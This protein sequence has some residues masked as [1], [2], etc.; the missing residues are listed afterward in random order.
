MNQK[1]NPMV[2][3][4]S[5][6]DVLGIGDLELDLHLNLIK[7][8]YLN[9]DMIPVDPSEPDML[10]GLSQTP[11]IVGGKKCGKFKSMTS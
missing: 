1:R 11:I 7:C 9:P 2:A 4:M 5:P 10:P 8:I 3:T 6:R